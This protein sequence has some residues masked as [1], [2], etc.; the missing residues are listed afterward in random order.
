[1]SILNMIKDKKIIFKFSYIFISLFILTN[2]IFIFST[3]TGFVIILLALYVI[4]KSNEIVHYYQNNLSIVN[5]IY[6]LLLSMYVAFSFAG[7]YLFIF[8]DTSSIIYRSFTFIM[9]ILLVLPNMILIFSKLDKLNVENSD[10]KSSS[11][12]KEHLFIHY[13]LIIVF[14]GFIYL[15]A[16]NPSIISYDSV[17]QY[18]QAVGL[19]PIDN[20]H[21]AFFTILMKIVLNIYESPISFSI[22]Q[23]L[24]FAMIVSSAFNHIKLSIFNKKKIILICVIFAFLPTNGLH[25]ISIWKDIT[26]SITILWITILIYRLVESKKDERLSIW[27]YSQ[28]PISLVLTLLLRHNGIVPFIVSF[29]T[30]M[31]IFII[32]KKYNKFLFLFISI[33]LFILIKGTVFDYYKVDRTEYPN[34]K[35]YGLLHDLENI[36]FWDGN[37]SKETYSFLKSTI[38]LD[39]HLTNRINKIHPFTE[40][41]YWTNILYYNQDELSKIELAE[42]IGMYLDTFIKNPVLTINA[43]LCR[44]DFIWNVMEGKDGMIPNV[45]DYTLAYDSL[46]YPTLPKLDIAPRIPNVLTSILKSASTYAREFDLLRIILWRFGIWFIGL[47][48]LGIYLIKRK[49]YSHLVLFIPVLSNILSLIIGN[50]WQDYR[51][52]WSIFLI[53]PFIIMWTLSDLAEKTY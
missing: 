2:H 53:V 42:F 39:E 23:I 15:I 38:N 21:P 24:Y 13:F 14:I 11:F 48:T 32:K 18:T 37:L 3:S 9:T 26:Y 41:Y 34:Y 20:R 16:F 4:F 7:N 44:T 36:Y 5:K 29:I 27:Y 31:C 22:M 10:L 28:I 52:A 25:V 46:N 19:V 6:L 17:D 49:K 47:I 35:Y 45:T 43:V 8:P 30:F 50:G 33:I 1:M 40:G 12:K 51:Y